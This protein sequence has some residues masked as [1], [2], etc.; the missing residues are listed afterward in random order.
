MTGS[1]EKNEK[2]K[3]T[4][5]ELHATIESLKL[6]LEAAGKPLINTNE[7]SEKTISDQG[8]AIESLKRE[9]EAA[10]KVIGSLDGEVRDRE[11]M[12]ENLTEEVSLLRVQTQK[13]D[14]SAKIR[15]LESELSVLR[16]ERVA[17][18]TRVEILSTTIQAQGELNE[19]LK[20][21]ISKL[22]L[23][24]SE[25]LSGQSISSIN[26]ANLA[27]GQTPKLRENITSPST[28]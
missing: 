12:I 15:T 3:Q 6:E 16:D 5:S 23:R 4:V 9:L 14:E 10:S 8:L 28:S 2:S 11:S 24:L 20:D 21:E 19:H 22:Q 13:S 18:T 25:L 7:K 1:N 27:E 17:E 26:A